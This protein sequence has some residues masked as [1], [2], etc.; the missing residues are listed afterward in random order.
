VR[1]VSLL[2]ASARSSRFALQGRRCP[3]PGGRVLKNSSLCD[4]VW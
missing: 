4:D 3:P 1:L 2:V